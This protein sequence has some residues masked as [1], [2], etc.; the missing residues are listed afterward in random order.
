MKEI[1][2]GDIR[3]GNGR[4]CVLIAGPCVIEDSETTAAIA[5]GLKSLSEDLA[6]PLIFKASYDKANRT[7]KDSYR[8]PGM[9]E[10]LRQVRQSLGE[11]GASSRAAKVVLSEC[12][13]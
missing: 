1:T 10:G 11:P 4:P 3:I 13:S 2:L 6:L 12:Q 9:K 5:G 7:S 8:G